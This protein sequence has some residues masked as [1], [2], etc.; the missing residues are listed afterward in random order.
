MLKQRE[1]EVA[2]FIASWTHQIPPSFGTLDSEQQLG[3]NALIL[4]FLSLF[5]FFLFYF[6]MFLRHSGL[7]C[8]CLTD[9]I[10]LLLYLWLPSLFWDRALVEDKKMHSHMFFNTSQKR[11]QV[12]ARARGEIYERVWS[13]SSSPPRILS[14]FIAF[15]ECLAQPRWGHTPEQG[16]RASILHYTPFIAT[17]RNKS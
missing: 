2:A 13:S 14:I 12:R 7:V 11:L 6:A 16:W 15:F 10:P 3:R 1:A 4:L 5:F 17:C 9:L 8:V